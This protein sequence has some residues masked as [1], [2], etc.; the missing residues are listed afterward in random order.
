MGIHNQNFERL[1]EKPNLSF[2]EALYLL[3][4]NCKI[5]RSK[6]DTTWYIKIF[7]A[8]NNPQSGSRIESYSKQ[9]HLIENDW[10]PTGTELLMSDWFFVA[11]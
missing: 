11:D 3:K 5:R 2:E 6:W 4:Q 7:K 1:K 8:E 10:R 9:G